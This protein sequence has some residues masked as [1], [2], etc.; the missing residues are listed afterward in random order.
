MKAWPDD[1]TYRLSRR[2]RIVL[3]LA[4]TAWLGYEAYSLLTSGVDACSGG[5]IGCG[6]AS[7]LS[8]VFGISRNVALADFYITLALGGWVWEFTVSANKP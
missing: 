5:G 2:G 1:W 8:T 4:L 3:G 6:V 7:A